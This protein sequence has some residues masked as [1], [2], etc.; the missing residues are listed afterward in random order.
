MTVFLHK[1]E[2]LVPGSWG[3]KGDALVRVAKAGLPVAPGFL[4][5][6]GSK[7]N[8]P[9]SIKELDKHLGRSF[10]SLEE[11]YFLYVRLLPLEFKPGRLETAKY[12]G[13]HPENL[14]SDA[15]EILTRKA[16]ISVWSQLSALSNQALPTL[17]DWLE[18]QG[19]DPLKVS[20]SKDQVHEYCKAI[21]SE[22]GQILSADPLVQ[23]SLMIETLQIAEPEMP[24]LVATMSPIDISVSSLRARLVSRDPQTGATGVVGQRLRSRLIGDTNGRVTGEMVLPRLETLQS[25]FRTAVDLGSESLENTFQDIMEFDVSVDKTDWH[26]LHLDSAQS[27]PDASL[28]LA[29]DLEHRGHID[30][31]E[32]LSRLS[33]AELEGLLHS[34]LDPDVEKSLLC[35]GFAAAPGAVSG[36][37]VF[38]AAEALERAKKGEAIILAK[39]ETQPDDVRAMMAAAGVLTV[40]GGMTSH[41][42][43]IARGLGK[44]AIVGARDLAIDANRETM[45]AGSLTLNKDDLVTLDG[46]TGQVLFG[47]VP[48]RPPTVT[49]AFEQLMSWADGQARLSVRANTE[50]VKELGDA[51]ALGAKGV[52]LCRTEHMLFA[53]GRL[54]GLRK[55]ILVEDDASR[56]DAVDELKVLQRHDL[57]ELFKIADG[58][59]MTVRLLDPPLHEFL[60]HNAGE[61]KHL[62]DSTGLP[63]DLIIRRGRALMEANPMLGHRGCRLGITFP[64][65]YDMQIRA[66]LEAAAAVSAATGNTAHP[67]IMIPLVAFAAEAHAI[68][69]RIE[70]ISQEVSPSSSSIRLDIKVG[71][72]IELPRA[73]LRADRIAEAVDFF[74]FGTND[75]T[76]TTFGISR[77]DAGKFL[78]DYDR[79]AVMSADP[80]NT[81]DTYGV[82]E[83]IEIACERGR[84]VN[85]KL[86]LG[87]CGE[88]GGDPASIAFFERLGLDYISC[89]PYRVP[90]ARLAAAQAISS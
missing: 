76:Q 69:D 58:R 63:R 3:E 65:I 82:G 6:S 36:K 4:L 46:A 22:A 10:G 5:A 80:F 29:V 73:C 33:A 74:S 86:V 41:A 61:V 79:L 89:S 88:H 19:F 23:L 11:G 54:A 55:F 66:I 57:E 7:L 53:P 1:L 13:L 81:L 21:E 52:G 35:D 27:S 15:A 75:L 51:L 90:I 45:V 77:D 37:V 25:G 28:Q 34:T 38:D 50:S 43:V 20:P 24:I 16:G 47:A 59:P 32:A 8:L 84:R 2:T 72:M 83:L 30:Q 60:P 67:E 18:E 26:I 49:P 14:P 9:G 39:T 40:R 17:D 71:A 64:E 70:K 42:A 85:S 48:T 62:S 31:R 68:R 44:P 87:V 56:Q 12:L 78:S